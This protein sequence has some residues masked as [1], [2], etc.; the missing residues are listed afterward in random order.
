MA[1]DNSLFYNRDENISGVTVYPDYSGL[2]LTPSYGSS[3]TF[4]SKI[5]E[6]DTKDFYTNSVPNSMN[7]LTAEF[8]VT[9]EVSEDQAKSI[10]AFIESKNGDS[11]FDFN[12]DNSGIYKSINGTCDGYSIQHNNDQHYTVSA[13]FNVDQ[14]PN[15]FN[16]SGMNFLNYQFDEWTPSAEYQ[17]YDITYKDENSNKLMN[18]YYCSGNHTALDENIDGPTGS[19]TKWTQE[20]FF[21]PDIGFSTN[22]NLKND[23][24]EFDNSFPLRIKNNDNNAGLSFSYK[25]ENITTKQLK[26]ML[27]FLE[28]KA[29]YRRFKHQIPSVFNRPKVFYCDEWTHT[30]KYFDS[31]DLTVKFTEDVFGVIE[32]GS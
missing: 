3:V 6:Y 20:F 11:L 2:Q 1:I 14:A 24:I 26:S 10:A 17:E 23:K 7:S 29:G 12:I 30:W 15:L 8:D 4:K 9:Y 21:D 27:H 13:K 32:S 28:T 5:S 19:S 22:V 31:H 25:Y 16:W 18:F